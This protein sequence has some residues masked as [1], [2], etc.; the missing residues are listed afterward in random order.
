[1]KVPKI[2]TVCGSS[3]FIEIMAVVAWLL[4]RDEGAITMGLHLLPWWYC[5]DDIPDHL[6]E[7]EGCSD[8]LDELHLKKIE[9]SDEVYVVDQDGYIGDSTRREIAHAENLSIPIRYHSQD[10]TS[11]KVLNIIRSNHHLMGKV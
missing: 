11:E 10:I 1:M 4:E 9:I 5:V 7:H 6:A 8:E 2:I 3:R